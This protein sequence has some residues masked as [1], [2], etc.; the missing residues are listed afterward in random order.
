VRESL[1]AGFDKE[2]RQWIRGDEPAEAL[3]QLLPPRDMAGPAEV[4]GIVPGAAADPEEKDVQVPPRSR[5]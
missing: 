5:A 2:V 4:L 1:E 3:V